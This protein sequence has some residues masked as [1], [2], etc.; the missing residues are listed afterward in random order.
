[1]RQHPL[2]VSLSVFAF[3]LSFTGISLAQDLPKPQPQFAF[4]KEQQDA[5]VA[6]NKVYGRWFKLVE[7]AEMGELELVADQKMAIDAAYQKMRAASEMFN[8]ER[9][10][11]QETGPNGLDGFD[12]QSHID[13]CQQLLET[14]ESELLPHQKTFFRETLFLELARRS[15]GDRHL[16]AMPIDFRCPRCQLRGGYDTN[17]PVLVQEWL[18]NKLKLTDDQKQDLESLKADYD[19]QAKAIREKFEADLRALGKQFN[20]KARETLTAEQRETLEN[21]GAV[22]GQ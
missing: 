8:A 9:K 11:R 16:Q 7:M 21:L 2:L 19:K 1:M 4:N 5:L 3:T 15:N 22:T 12:W 6:M 10:R 14:A 18:C 20:G 17:A 13:E